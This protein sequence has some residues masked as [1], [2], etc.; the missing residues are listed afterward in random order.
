MAD[1]TPDFSAKHPLEHTWTLWFDNPNGRQKQAT[2]GQTLRSVYTFNT[3][4]DFWCLYNNILAPSRLIMGTD[5]HL[6]KEGI[7]PKW[8]DATCAKGGKWTFFFPKSKEPAHLDDCWLNLLLA[9]IGEQFCEPSEICGATSKA[10]WRCPRT[11][12]SD[13]WCTTTRFASRG[14]RKIGTRSSWM[15][16]G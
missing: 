12:K 2:W 3:V 10:C 5:F 1:A 9:M 7:E 6:F 16:R 14:E 4:E 8:E 15:T 13:T 11:R